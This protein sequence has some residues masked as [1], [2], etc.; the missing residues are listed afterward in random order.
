MCA[1]QENYLCQFLL[2][3]VWNGDLLLL[4]TKVIQV[5][6][7]YTIINYNFKH[8]VLLLNLICLLE[9]VGSSSTT[10]HKFY[11]YV[12][13][14]HFRMLMISKICSLLC[15]NISISQNEKKI[16]MT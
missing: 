1:V 2:G 11:L 13:S 6:L 5:T 10:F 7:I 4:K 9:D 15:R 3:I 8:I 16:S 14:H 12:F